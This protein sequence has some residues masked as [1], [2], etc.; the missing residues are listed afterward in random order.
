M[1]R[2]LSKLKLGF[3]LNVTGA[4]VAGVTVANITTIIPLTAMEATTTR[5]YL[6]FIFKEPTVRRV[7][8]LSFRYYNRWYYRDGTPVPEDKAP[9]APS[10][11][12]AAEPNDAVVFPGST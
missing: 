2:K 10:A 3:W 6:F 1:A 7:N 11:P 9:P 12:P 8:V 5:N 4:G